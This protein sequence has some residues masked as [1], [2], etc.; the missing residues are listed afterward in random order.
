MFKNRKSLG[1]GVEN[2]IRCSWRW[3]L[4]NENCAPFLSRNKAIEPE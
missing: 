4:F 3:M 1:I 2:E